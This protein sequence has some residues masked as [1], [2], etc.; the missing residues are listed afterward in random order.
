MRDRLYKSRRRSSEVLTLHMF[1]ITPDDIARLDDETLRTVIARLCEADLRRRG[2]STAFVTSGGNQNAR[3]GGIDVRVALPAGLDIDGFVPRP[4]TGF[5]VK[6]Q[7]MPPSE[8]SDEM[9]PGGTL[10]GSIQDLANRSG[11]YIIVSS[12]GS[13]ADTALTSR[14]EAMKQAVA[15]ARHAGQLVLEF[16]DRG[17]VASWVRS[18]EGL[19]PWVRTLV[20][21]AITGWHSYGN[22]AYAPEAATAEYLLDEKLRMQ[23]AKRNAPTGISIL[24][25]IQLLRDQLC[26]PQRVVRLVGLS[27]VGKTRLVQ[28][29]FDKRVGTNSLNPTLAIYT[30]VADEPEPDPITLASNLVAAG[31]EAI[32]VIDN[33]PSALHR[34]LAEICAQTH[35]K[36]S[37]ITI[38][39]D[40]REDEPE[41]TEI[42]TLETASPE[43]IEKLIEQRFQNVSQIDAHKIAEFSGGNARIAIALAATMERSET[44]AG[45][46]DDDLFQRLFDQRHTPDQSLYLAAQACALVYSFEG[47][48]VSE[49]EKAELIRIGALIGQTPDELYRSVAELK[50]RDLVQQRGRWRAVLPHA[51]ANRLA[52]VALQNIPYARI[53]GQLLTSDRLMKSFSRRLGYLHASKEAAAIVMQWLGN[54]G[55][56]ED[57]AHLNELGQAMFEN[58]APVAPEAILAAL[59]RACTGRPSPGT[60][61]LNV[62]RSLAYESALF[63]RCARLIAETAMADPS[64]AHAREVFASLFYLCL[65]GTRA[66]IEQRLAVIKGLLESSEP[67]RQALGAQAM[68]AALEAWHFQ[69][70]STFDFGARPR[71]FGY[72]PRNNKEA[73]D[74]FQTVL[75][76][77]EAAAC[78][79]TPGATVA[80]A[81]LA[82]KFRGLWARGGVHEELADLSRKINAMRFWPQGWLAVRQT[83]HYDGKGMDPERLSQLVELEQEL[84]PANLQQQV[85]SIVLS[86]RLHAVDLDDFEDHTTEDIAT[87]M[88][89]TE[90][91]ARDLGRATATQEQALAELLPELVS[92]EGKLW[93]FG[94]GMFEGAPEPE[95]LWTRILVALGAVEERFRR[96]QLLQGFLNAAHQKNP[97]F[98]AR[99]LEQ[100]VD[101]PT[102]AAAF[103]VLQVAVPVDQQGVARLK[104]SLTLGIA[105]ARMYM[106]LSAGRAT[107][108]IPPVDLKEIIVMIA[109]LPSGYDVALDVLHMRLHSDNE[110]KQAI[111]PELVDTGCELLRQLRFKRNDREDYRLGIIVRNCLT[112][113]CGAK[114]VGKLCARLKAA[115]RRYE[116]SARFHDD[117]LSG[118]FA[119]QPVAALNGLC[120]GDV[121]ELKRGINILRDV[122][123]RA[124]VFALFADKELLAWCEQEPH[125]RYPAMAQVIPFAEVLNERQRRWTSAALALLGGAPD[126]A[127]VLRHFVA[128]FHPCGGWS[129][130]LTATIEANIALLDQLATYAAL[131]EVVATEKARL[132]SSITDQRRRETAWAHQRDERF[133]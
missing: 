125:T 76:M 33:A 11:A 109:E 36:M 48:D 67:G 128:R 95:Q 66:T 41:G 46:R 7:D 81:A 77:V 63:E 92:G 61:Y 32:L 44:L 60:R 130:S 101:D 39:Y 6:R 10:R 34:R 89:R 21:R 112:G 86:T 73:H 1:E 19:I 133:E 64:H 29:L 2:Y 94:A 13:T 126:P 84:R 20:G 122:E 8:I 75:N 45:L 23:P 56:L 54:G 71:D 26:Q 110:R 106:Y 14:R 129:E 116:T 57:I 96:V 118:L 42:F 47:A 52:A 9:R 22:W 65:S 104:R 28:A 58:I 68:K 55:L 74:W 121:K 83:L 102:L 100:S 4:A 119:A 131:A 85:R 88:A 18:H 72:W 49:D 25:G 79:Q 91:L 27:G 87:R 107:D 30:N 51:I 103:P 90:A 31:T 105:P 53:S 59:E 35:S 98:A 38:E 24:K 127:S 123:G 117:L 3:D 16:Y 12:Q 120:G 113:G 43:L 37:V 17:R 124:N 114:T 69:A 70:V 15:T 82:E 99:L 132:Q 108:P 40:I 80:R 5:Q 111:A 97:A 78:G 50:R 62:L 93:S 115:I